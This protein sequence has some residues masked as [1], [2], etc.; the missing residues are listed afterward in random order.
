MSVWSLAWKRK[1]FAALESDL[2]NL[3]YIDGH[4]SRRK[5]GRD[6]GDHTSTLVRAKL[7]IHR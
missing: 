7:G 3:F 4:V 5:E 6:L 2:L 1:K